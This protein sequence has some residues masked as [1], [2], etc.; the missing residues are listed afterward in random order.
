MNKHY[1]VETKKINKCEPKDCKPDGKCEP[2]DCKPDGKCEPKD[3]KPDG[4]CEPKDCK[5][6]GK[7]DPN[8]CKPGGKYDPISGKPIH[9]HSKYHKSKVINCEETSIKTVTPKPLRKRIYPKEGKPT[10]QDNAKGLYVLQVYSALSKEDADAKY[11]ELKSEG[12]EKVWVSTYTNSNVVW[13]RVRIGDFA[14]KSAAD[15]KA[16]ELGITTYWVDKI[17]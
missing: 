16:R 15:A 2:K 8:D 10:L 7:C 4:K 12:V 3:C 1:V 17:R 13:Y 14:T 11:E 6:G 9:H 5:P